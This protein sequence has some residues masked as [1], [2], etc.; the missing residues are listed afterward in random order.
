[1]IFGKRVEDSQHSL[2]ALSGWMKTLAFRGILRLVD[3]DTPNQSN[4]STHPGFVYRSS[5]NEFDHPSGIDFLLVSLSNNPKM[6]IPIL[7]LP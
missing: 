4:S 7:R 3:S 5:S 1:M 6:G 2:L